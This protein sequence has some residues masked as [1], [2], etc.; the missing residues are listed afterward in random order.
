M[1]GFLPFSSS[2]FSE[3]LS[4]N[5]NIEEIIST[6]YEV[7]AESYTMYIPGTIPE[8]ISVFNFYSRDLNAYLLIDLNDKKNKFMPT[9]TE[10]RSYDEQKY[11]LVFDTQFTYF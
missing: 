8:P 7:A 9:V 4:F 3:F 11:H 6:S 2:P 10:S 5:I 1:L